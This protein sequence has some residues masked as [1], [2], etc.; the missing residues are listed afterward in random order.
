MSDKK[1]I[2]LV[3]A[4]ANGMELNAEGTH[5][6]ATAEHASTLVSKVA[7]APIAPAAARALALN[8]GWEDYAGELYGSLDALISLM[9]AACGVDG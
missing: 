5:L 4:Q 1:R 6:W 2:A 3:L 9:D 8:A 7:G